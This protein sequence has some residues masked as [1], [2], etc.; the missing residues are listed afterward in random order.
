MSGAMDENTFHTGSF[1]DQND[2]DQNN[3]D[4]VEQ[5]PVS[6]H[7]MAGIGASANISIERRPRKNAAVVA[8]PAR[9]LRHRRSFSYARRQR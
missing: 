5:L 2:S 9:P 1:S 7:Q 6:Q 4:S 3:A 8:N